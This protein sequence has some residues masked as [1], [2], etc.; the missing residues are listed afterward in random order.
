[1]TG[2]IHFVGGPYDPRQE[3]QPG[4]VSV[5]DDAGARIASQWVHGYGHHFRIRLRP[6]GYRL[7]TGR[8]LP[9]SPVECRPLAVR[10]RPNHFT[11]VVVPKGC[12]VP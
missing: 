1:V 9:T 4:L 3:P 5:F 11:R 12:G 6:G 8:T 7:V 2:I 10:V